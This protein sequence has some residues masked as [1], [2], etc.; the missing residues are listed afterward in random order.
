MEILGSDFRYKKSP[1]QNKFTRLV[2]ESLDE[3]AP[4]TNFTV[5]SKHI[6]GLS[7]ETKS[8]MKQRDDNNN[9]NL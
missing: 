3:L 4:M 8:L 6:F 1:I 7:D 5:K 2:A 9:N